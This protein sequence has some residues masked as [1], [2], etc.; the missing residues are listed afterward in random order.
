M[1][2]QWR[3]L[4]EYCELTLH[5][6]LLMS[7]KHAERRHLELGGPLLQAGAAM[8]DLAIVYSAALVAWVTLS[9][10]SAS[11]QQADAVGVS[12]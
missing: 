1:P 8:V 6:L 3:S 10:S 9:E 4:P 7:G 11:S 5:H 2:Q 12:L